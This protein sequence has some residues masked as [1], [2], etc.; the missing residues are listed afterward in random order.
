VVERQTQVTERR[1]GPFR[2]NLTT[3]RNP[4]NIID[5]WCSFRGKL[6]LAKRHVDAVVLLP[7]P[8]AFF[9]ALPRP[10]RLL[11]EFASKWKLWLWQYFFDRPT[12][13]SLLTYIVVIWILNTMQLIIISTVIMSRPMCVVVIR[14]SY[15][16][17]TNFVRYCCLTSSSSLL[18]R[19]RFGLELSASC[20]ASS[21]KKV[22]HVHR[23]KSTV[24][25]RGTK[26]PDT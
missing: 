9:S 2:L 18:P 20:L 25:C 19:H 11:L 26:T 10:R 6:S 23:C 16:L 12:W 3:D 21:L 24:S 8:W 7:R 15:K 17:F 14:I 5:Q 4:L 1:S 22:P 13:N